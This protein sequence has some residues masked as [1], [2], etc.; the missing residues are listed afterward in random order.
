MTGGGF[1]LRRTK[2]V[3][4]IGPASIHRVDDLVAA[5]MDVARI[6]FSHGTAAEHEA[7]VRAVHA[8][9][10]RAGRPVA[11]MVDLAG[12]KVRLGRLP[13]GGVVLATGAT[14]ALRRGTETGDA[15]G[16][17]TNHDGLARDMQPGDRISLADGAVGVARDGYS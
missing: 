3:A 15:H 6:N 1:E 16:A 7:A 9:A 11:V 4:T 8:A 10:A 13:P 2:I 17:A 12:P 5:G 14:F